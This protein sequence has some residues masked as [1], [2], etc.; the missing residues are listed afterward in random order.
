MTPDMGSPLL[1]LYQDGIFEGGELRHIIPG[2]S[3]LP[4]L[5]LPDFASG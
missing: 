4:S 3:P 1:P 5:V 2:V